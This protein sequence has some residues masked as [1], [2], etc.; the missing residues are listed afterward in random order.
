MKIFSFF[1]DFR[2]HVLTEDTVERYV[3]KE[4][5]LF[6]KRLLSKTNRV[7][8]WAEKLISSRLVFIIEESIVDPINK[9]FSTYTRNIGMQHL[10]SIEERVVYKISEENKNW[11]VAERKA[12]IDSKMF[13]LAKAIQ[14]FG[15]ER[16]KHNCSKACKGFQLVLDALYSNGDNNIDTA[17][18]L[19][20]PLLRERIK[21]KAKHFKEATKIGVPLVASCSRLPKSCGVKH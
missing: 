14:A 21:E 20:H 9:I 5:K 18:T 15:V 17:T 3:D 19:L 10:L 7:P 4:G 1:N 13:G 12:S 16:F 2:K 11:T 6:T 8:Q